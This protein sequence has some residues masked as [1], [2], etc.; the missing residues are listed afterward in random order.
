MDWIGAWPRRW[1]SAGPRPWPAFWTL[2]QGRGQGPI[3]P[4]YYCYRIGVGICYL[5][6]FKSVIQTQVNSLELSVGRGRGFSFSIESGRT[7]P[8]MRIM[9]C[10]QVIQTTHT[11]KSHFLQHTGNAPT[12]CIGDHSLTRPVP[13]TA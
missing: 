13:Y 5:N 6:P 12:G 2:G 11:C 4:I 3:Q 1:P 9:W 7:T 10:L 8:R